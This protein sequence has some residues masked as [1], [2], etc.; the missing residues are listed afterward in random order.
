MECANSQAY[1]RKTLE[2]CMRFGKLGAMHGWAVGLSV[3]LEWLEG[4][5]VNA[6][7]RQSWSVDK[8]GRR[9]MRH[10][11]LER[12]LAVQLTTELTT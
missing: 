3:A 10:P 7:I 11:M 6:T 5:A 9:A 2:N 12:R 1:M 8:H 4:A